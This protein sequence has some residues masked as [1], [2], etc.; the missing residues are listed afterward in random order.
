MFHAVT[1]AG[2]Y[3]QLSQMIELITRYPMA[4]G[5]KIFSQLKRSGR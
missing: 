5:A 4:R 1:I 2:H 3:T